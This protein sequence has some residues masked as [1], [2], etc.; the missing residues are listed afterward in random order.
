V[1]GQGEPF[2]LNVTDHT[3]RIEFGYQGSGPGCTVSGTVGTA[4]ISIDDS[5]SFTHVRSTGNPRY[6]ITGS[7][8]SDDTASGQLEVF[9][10]TGCVVTI[11]TSWSATKT[12]VNTP[13]EIT[14]DG[15]GPDAT[16]N[17]SENATAVTTVT[18]T[19]VDPGTTLTYSISDGPDA[20]KFTI[21][22]STGVLTFVS[23]PDFENPTDAGSDNVYNVTVR[24][25]DGTLADTQAID[26]NVTSVNDN[27]PSITSNGADDTAIVQ[28]AENDAFVTS[29]EASDADLP[30]PTLS[31]S[32]SGGVDATEF[33]IDPGSGA[34]TFISAPDFETPTDANGDN[35]YSV[36]V[37]ASDGE[38]MDTQSID[39]VVTDVNERLDGDYNDDGNVDAADYVLWRHALD[40]MVTPSTGADGNGDGTVNQADYDVWRTNFGRM[41]PTEEGASVVNALSTE[42]G[43]LADAPPTAEPLEA[44]LK[45]ESAPASRIN[46]GAIPTVKSSV[47]NDRHSRRDILVSY[48]SRDNALVAWLASQ[49]VP[50]RYD[51]QAGCFDKLLGENRLNDNTQVA[52]D[53]VDLAFTVRPALAKA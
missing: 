44:H 25:S 34:L 2:S 32:I 18:A 7:F 50:A 13:P 22:S 53:V 14:S 45:R 47:R 43:P 29:V 8:P 37:S 5:H 10:P 17:V 19:D 23:A 30:T 6:T 11:L 12:P 46:E 28:V 4:V 36:V 41:A 16:R 33:M 51:S 42:A 15:G 1:T 24:A 48:T 38:L 39:V 21:N 9:V 27:N 31:F 3:M 35:V 49:P 52:Q 26:V 20:A 40:T